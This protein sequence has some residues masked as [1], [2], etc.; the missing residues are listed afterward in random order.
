MKTRL[1][2]LP[3]FL[4]LFLLNSYWCYSQNN[5]S[6]IRIN[7][8]SKGFGGFYFK[9]SNSEGGG[10]SFV[11]N[12]TLVSNKNLVN[13]CF[14]TGSEIGV[15]GGSTYNF[16]EFSV[17]YGRELQLKKWFSLEGFAGIGNYNQSSKNSTIISGNTVSFPLK[18]NIKF[19]FTNKMGVGIYNSQSVN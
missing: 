18:L 8:I 15:V 17:A 10:A 6:K 1:L 11:L 12:G 7:S 14:L 9:K 13:L 19:Y 4:L 3:F 5:D 16:N 2:A